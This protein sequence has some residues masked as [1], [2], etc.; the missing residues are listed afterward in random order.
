M[1]SKTNHSPFY[2]SIFKEVF[3]LIKNE[4]PVDQYYDDR[5]L[6]IVNNLKFLTCGNKHEAAL[7]IGCGLGQASI[8]LSSEYAFVVAADISKLSLK[9]LLEITKRKK[10]K[11]IHPIVCDAAHLPFK[12]GIFD[13]II[14][15][16]ALEWVPM[17][18]D[19]NPFKIQL[20][21]T[22]EIERVLDKSGFLWL[23]IENRMSYNYLLGCMDHHSS[24][25][26]ITFLPRTIANFYSKLVKKRP[27]KTYLYNY[28]E[29]KKLLRVSGLDIYKSYT[30]FPYYS[31]PK[32]VCD[33]SDFDE[34]E[35]SV[36]RMPFSSLQKTLI[37]SVSKM[38][39]TKLFLH[40]F[41]LICRK[42][43]M[44]RC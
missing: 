27:Y 7:D 14:C 5:G 41:I 40:S 11:N 12:N 23:G 37:I 24:L 31:N 29:L 22:S 8:S 36:M 15:S 43:S 2:N 42:S 10:I 16:G 4:K 35:R 6:N 38:K 19:I 30:A 3:D 34:I 20:Q 33:I 17:A 26:G 39:L 13:T 25:R 1:S 28:W 18:Y 21:A 32:V 9:I 44:R